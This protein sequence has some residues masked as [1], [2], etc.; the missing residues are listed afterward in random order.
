MKVSV[1]KILADV[2]NLLDKYPEPYTYSLVIEATEFVREKSF[3]T[4]PSI[5]VVN[6]TN[7]GSEL[8]ADLERNVPLHDVRKRFI[9]YFKQV[10]S[11]VNKA[12]NTLQKNDKKEFLKSITRDFWEKI[13]DEDKKAAEQAEHEGRRYG[14]FW[15]PFFIGATALGSIFAYSSGKSTKEYIE[16]K[17]NKTSPI[18]Y[19]GVG[20]IAVLGIVTL[21]RK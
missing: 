19:A 9:V 16:E 6:I 21:V 1:N 13:S 5:S 7:P 17:E 12:A 20:A 8:I 10:W 14:A 2:L 15:I 11:V 4:A 3:E 18:L